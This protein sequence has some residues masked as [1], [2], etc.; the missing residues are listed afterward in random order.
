MGL[1]FALTQCNDDRLLSKD[2][3]GIPAEKQK[4]RVG[5]KSRHVLQ[6]E[7]VANIIQKRNGETR[8]K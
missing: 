5:G 2:Q 4:I 3:C 6:E 8:L 7:V 1:S